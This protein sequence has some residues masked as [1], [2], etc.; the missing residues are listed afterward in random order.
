MITIQFSTTRGL[1]SRYI[2]WFTW[3]DFSH[4]DV[5]L[6][7]GSLL[8]AQWDGIKVRPANYQKFSK[9]ARFKASQWMKP[10]QELLFWQFLKEQLGKRYDKKSIIGFLF[11]RDWRQEE[12]W[13]CSEL[14]A[15]GFE[16]A[17]FPLI[18]RNVNRVTPGMLISSTRLVPLD[19]TAKALQAAVA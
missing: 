17:G 6:E 9:I 16:Y 8:G 15:A 2:R 10:E 1:L 18:N 3:S 14:V 5:V 12:S 13:F 7:D 11:R 4:V 19:D